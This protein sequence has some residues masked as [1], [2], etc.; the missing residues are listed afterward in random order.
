MTS[1][2]SYYGKFAF[3]Y[4]FSSRVLSPMLPAAQTKKTSFNS[5]PRKFVLS[6]KQFRKSSGMWFRQ[7]ISSNIKDHRTTNIKQQTDCRA[8]HQLLMEIKERKNVMQHHTSHNI[9]FR[10][11]KLRD[12]LNTIFIAAYVNQNCKMYSICAPNY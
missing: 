11:T 9:I 8:L 3:L 12:N 4:F 5:L 6:P 2:L 7:I 10:P 1:T